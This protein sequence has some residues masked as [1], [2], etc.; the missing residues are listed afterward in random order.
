MRG[1]FFAL[2]QTGM[3]VRQCCAVCAEHFVLLGGV[4]DRI[5]FGFADFAAFA[6]CIAY[7][8]KII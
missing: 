4:F 7:F 1:I 3:V 2:W 6:L 5:V 8:S